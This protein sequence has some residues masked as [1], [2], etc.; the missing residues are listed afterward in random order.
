MLADAMMV[1]KPSASVCSQGTERQR[2]WMDRFGRCEQRMCSVPASVRKL[3]NDRS[4]TGRADPTVTHSVPTEGG[5]PR[6]SAGKPGGH[7][8]SRAQVRAVILRSVPVARHLDTVEVGGM[9][10]RLKQTS[11]SAC[12]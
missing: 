10:R 9:G 2:T 6:V 8:A 1:C 5:G 12:P 11:V 4:A 3:V 7:L